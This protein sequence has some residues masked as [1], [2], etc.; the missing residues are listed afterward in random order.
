MPT[1]QHPPSNP[2][3]T[4]TSGPHKDGHSPSARKVRPTHLQREAGVGVGREGLDGVVGNQARLWDGLPAQPHAALLPG[5]GLHQHGHQVSC[6]AHCGVACASPGKGGEGNWGTGEG[7]W[8]W[9]V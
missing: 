4:L 8:G 3:L 7:N 9:L 2:D 5:Q 6:Q 1:C